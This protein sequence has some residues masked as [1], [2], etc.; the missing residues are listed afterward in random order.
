[1]IAGRVASESK[2]PYPIGAG[3]EGGV[4][5]SLR[6]KSCRQQVIRLKIGSV[7]PSDG[8]EL[9]GAQFDDVVPLSIDA[10]ERREAVIS[11]SMI[12]LPR[13]EEPAGFHRLDCHQR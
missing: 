3:A 8:Q 2:L 7:V 6:I 10:I 1:M 4:E 12:Q 13:R 5:L 9:A 11:E